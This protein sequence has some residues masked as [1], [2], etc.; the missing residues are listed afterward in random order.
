[1]RFSRPEEILMKSLG[2]IIRTLFLGRVVAGFFVLSGFTLKQLDSNRSV[3]MESLPF[4]LA[5]LPARFGFF[6][7]KLV[8]IKHDGSVC[9]PV[10][11]NC[12]ECMKKSMWAS[13]EDAVCPSFFLGAFRKGLVKRFLGPQ[14]DFDPFK[15]EKNQI[16]NSHD[17]K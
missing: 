14:A 4:L 2:A 6:Q 9:S 5:C 12:T 8:P 16:Y 11:V 7:K 3:K 10:C 13:V 15:A 1:M 17:I